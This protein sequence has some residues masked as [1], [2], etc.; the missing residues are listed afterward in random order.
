[1]LA[2]SG[3]SRQENQNVKERGLNDVLATNEQF[4]AKTIPVDCSTE[5]EQGTWDMASS[6]ILLSIEGCSAQRPAAGVRLG[7]SICGV[8][9]KG[10]IA[11]QTVAIMVSIHGIRREVVQIT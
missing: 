2:G 3:E 1:L 11:K 6:S 5:C 10:A 4:M 9:E 8:V 7:R